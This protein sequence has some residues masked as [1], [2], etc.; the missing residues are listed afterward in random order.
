[1]AIV[2]RDL[3][4]SQQ[5]MDYHSKFNTAVAAS[6]G[7]SYIGYRA[8][9]PCT[10]K[11]IALAAEAV[12]GT[13]SLSFSLQ[14]FVVGAGSTTYTGVGA[15]TA[16]LAYGTSGAVSVSMAA[17]GSTLLNMNSNDLLIVNQLFSGG[18]VALTGLE[19]TVVVQALQDIK[20]YFNV[21]T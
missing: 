12:S 15:T 7:N 6:A 17:A 11:Q 4:V 9:Y 21:A 3:D 14:R 20:Q 5:Q 10:I 8:A 13:P 19:V 16:V 18:N 2:N 1:M